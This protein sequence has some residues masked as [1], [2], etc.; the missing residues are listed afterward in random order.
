LIKLAGR[1]FVFP[2]QRSYPCVGCA[3]RTGNGAHGA[4][5]KL[6]EVQV[7]SYLGEDDIL[8]FDDEYG[9]LLEG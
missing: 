6:I 7:G 4:L 1:L 8:R 5:Y 9:R 2:L 3:A